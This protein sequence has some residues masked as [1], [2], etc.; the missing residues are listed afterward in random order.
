MSNDAANPPSMPL[1][2]AGA[3]QVKSVMPFVEAER[4]L[5]GGHAGD[6]DT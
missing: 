3:Y 6:S 5:D 4:V 1:L 2:P